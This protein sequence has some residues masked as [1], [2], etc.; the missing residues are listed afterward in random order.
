VQCQRGTIIFV[1]SLA[2]KHVTYIGVAF[3]KVT[4]SISLWRLSFYEYRKG[5]YSERKRGDGGSRDHEI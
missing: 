4:S 2:W 5:E 3:G 1:Q